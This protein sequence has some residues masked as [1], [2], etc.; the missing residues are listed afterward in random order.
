[1]R[2]FVGINQKEMIMTLS[3]KSQKVYDR[4]V[5]KAELASWC[6]QTV[7][8]PRLTQIA[9]LL[10]ELNINHSLSETYCHKYT[11]AAGLRYST[12]G[13]TKMYEGHELRVWAENETGFKMKL[14]MNN[15]DTYYSWNTNR[16]AKDL[17]KFISNSQK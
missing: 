13:G 5:N 3:K 10:E 8:M 1:M 15:T 17:L 4:L 14:T 2:G 16:L 12:G 11:S 6:T 7:R 9:A